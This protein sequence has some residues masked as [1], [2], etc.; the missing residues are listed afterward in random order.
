MIRPKSFG[1]A[2][3]YF[4]LVMRTSRPLGRPCGSSR[5]RFGQQ[6]AGAAKGRPEQVRSAETVA[7]YTERSEGLGHEVLP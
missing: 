1:F 6:R 7:K 5:R 2:S 4:G 3:V